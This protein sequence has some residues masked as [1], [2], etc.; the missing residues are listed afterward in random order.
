MPQKIY[1][2]MNINE[3]KLFFQFLFGNMERNKTKRRY[4]K[5]KRK[6]TKN[7]L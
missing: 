7:N 4:R 2:Q 3:L 1:S 6:T 5:R